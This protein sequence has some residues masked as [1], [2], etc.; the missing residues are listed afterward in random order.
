[1][2]TSITCHAKATGHRTGATQTNTMGGCNLNKG[3]G[4]A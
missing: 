4:D 2:H 1:M 3:W